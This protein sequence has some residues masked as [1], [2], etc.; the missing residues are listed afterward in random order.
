[1]D[2]VLYTGPRSL[3]TAGLGQFKIINVVIPVF[4][5]EDEWFD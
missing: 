3:R 2:T 5:P 4:D 1:M